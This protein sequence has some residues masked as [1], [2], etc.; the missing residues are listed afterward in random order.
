VTLPI[1]YLLDTNICVF[2]MNERPP[3]VRARMAAMTATGKKLAISSVTF[4]ELQYGIA[5][6]VQKAQNQ[7]RL[8]RFVAGLD[9][10]D[11]GQTAAARAADQR[12]RLKKLGQPIGPYDLLIAGHALALN[13][14]LVTNN[15]GEFGRVAGLTIEDWSL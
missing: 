15:T 4:H 13:A 1:L 8:D 7:K 12:A 9:V 5:N 14:V 6:S 3:Q 11:F 10:L 2:V